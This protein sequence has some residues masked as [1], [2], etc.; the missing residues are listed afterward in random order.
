MSMF[1][2]VAQVER[3]EYPPQPFPVVV[4]L[5]DTR[6]G[7][8]STA[9]GI[10]ISNEYYDISIELDGDLQEAGEQL[11]NLAMLCQQAI[12]SKIKGQETAF[13]R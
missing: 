13:S 5:M 7:I 1:E 10:V 4:S 11:S 12:A 2:A 8:S 3:R 9:N 6:V